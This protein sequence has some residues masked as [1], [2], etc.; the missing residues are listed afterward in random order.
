MIYALTIGYLQIDR[1][2]NEKITEASLLKNELG[3][4]IKYR[5]NVY[6]YNIIMV[7][8][9]QL[10]RPQ[11]DFFN[12][13][14][15]YNRILAFSFWPLDDYYNF[16]PITQKFYI[17]YSK[18]LKPYIISKKVQSSHIDFKG[19]HWLGKVFNDYK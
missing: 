19:D 6:D 9:L 16:N 14:G 18:A 2:S 12:E 15:E 17:S 3:N 10:L 4:K 13:I 7:K 8:D 5:I 1:K 11:T